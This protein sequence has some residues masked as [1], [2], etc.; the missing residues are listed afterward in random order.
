MIL[1]GLLLGSFVLLLAGCYP[2]STRVASLGLREQYQYVEGHTR[3]RKTI[4]AVRDAPM[5]A[6]GSYFEFRQDTSRSVL[7][8]EYTV[9]DSGHIEP[10]GAVRSRQIMVSAPFT[11][12][13]ENTH[14]R[15][16]RTFL[17]YL[18]LP[19]LLVTV[20]VETIAGGVVVA[21]GAFGVGTLEKAGAQL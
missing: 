15:R 5:V 18:G 8:G 13:D 10:Y 19:L 12:D 1:R 20:P 4:L 3:D 14:V 17:G 6:D 16:H 7:L 11:G 2:L 21:V 9:D